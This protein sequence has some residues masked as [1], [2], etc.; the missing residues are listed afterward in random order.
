MRR[1]LDTVGFFVLI[2]AFC[3]VVIAWL[4]SSCIT[5]QRA[6]AISFVTASDDPRWGVGFRETLG[7]SHLISSS[8]VSHVE[9]D[10]PIASVHWSRVT[11]PA[12]KRT[13]RDPN[14]RRVEFAAGWPFRALLCWRD[15]EA[16]PGG[17][18]GQGIPQTHTFNDLGIA[19]GIDTRSAPRDMWGD[20]GDGI[21]PLRPI[22]IG[23]VLNTLLFALL[24]W[25]ATR[26]IRRL[27][28]WD[29]TRR[30]LCE[31]CAYDLSGTAHE[32]CPECGEPCAQLAN[33]KGRL[34]RL[35]MLVSV[36]LAL[37]IVS[38]IALAWASALV[39]DLRNAQPKSGW[40]ESLPAAWFVRRYDAIGASRIV[41]IGDDRLARM[42][43]FEK[44]R[45][46]AL[47]NPAVIIDD[48]DRVRRIAEEPLRSQAFRNDLIA[49]QL[50]LGESRPE[51]IP[52]WATVP[53]SWPTRR[54]IQPIRWAVDA[55]GW[56]FLAMSYKLELRCRIDEL[57]DI[58]A[59]SFGG[60]WDGLTF[61]SWTWG[62]FFDWRVL[63]LRI[64]WR[65]FVIDTMIFA[66][67]WF[68]GLTL[69]A[70]LG[71]RLAPDKSNETSIT[72]SAL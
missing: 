45:A 25:A 30:R 1:R 22:W 49:K 4:C 3:T 68:L 38:T 67:V 41:C 53:E 19:W 7:R 46:G 28:R 50:V 59:C 39:V 56:P 5:L 65:G 15:I 71:L 62:W 8:N 29:R 13:I 31:A 36:A 60:V 9:S 6:S 20:H 61:R 43:E 26:S 70:R 42:L 14:V 11:Q 10:V 12:P 32:R 58:N 35:T 47:A 33:R 2:G 51:L 57:D 54:S 69:L 37:G 34:K 16:I 27:R 18:D 52:S 66:S 24:W 23:F 21:L 40:R 63:P 48:Q 55:R 72:P 44:R 17:I 64:I